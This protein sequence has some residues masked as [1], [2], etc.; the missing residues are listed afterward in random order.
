MSPDLRAALARPDYR[1]VVARAVFHADTTIRKYIWR[2]HRRSYSQSGQTMVGDKTAEDF[3]S[4]AIMRLVD[5]RRTFDANR[6]L[7]EN[8]NSITDSIISAEK[9][10]SDRSGIV[11]FLEE[12]GEL[13][14]RKDPISTAVDVEAAPDKK[15]RETEFRE[16]QR[17][18]VDAI[19]ASFDGDD[20]MQRYLEAI[21]AGFKR[22]EISE[23]MEI[24]GAKVDE[25][26]RKL[27][28]YARKFFGVTSFQ[29]LQNR[30]H[31]GK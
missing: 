26:R 16:D 13:S 8:L 10:R 6:S 2:G 12:T 17:R 14:E 1:E 11:D 19:K 30:L 28:K 29:E 4:E 21:S 3:V 9:K 20:Q 31:E 24:P 22:S 15:L 23:L 18:C 27:V 7:L 25:L 5:D